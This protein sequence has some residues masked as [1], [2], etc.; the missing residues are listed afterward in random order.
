MS[1]IHL[2]K[3]GNVRLNVNFGAQIIVEKSY[4]EWVDARNFY[5]T[6]TVKGRITVNDTNP[7][8]KF[9][10]VTPR[11]IELSTFKIYKDEE[12]QLLE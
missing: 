2:D 3:N 1:G 5:I 12:E 7:E 9:L 8:N 11:G 6:A 4:N 10:T